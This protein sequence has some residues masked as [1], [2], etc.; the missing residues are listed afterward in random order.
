MSLRSAS[1][2][3]KEQVIVRT[4]MRPKR[5]SEILSMGSSGRSAA[6]SS[7]AVRGTMDGA[8]EFVTSNTEMLDALLEGR[9]MRSARE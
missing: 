5:T 6:F 4:M 9:D 7:R 8:L 2:M 3:L 1:A